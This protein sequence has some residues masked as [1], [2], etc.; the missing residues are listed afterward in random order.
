MQERQQRLTIG[1]VPLHVRQE[2]PSTVTRFDA[3]DQC[4]DRIFHAHG[5]DDVVVKVLGQ[6]CAG[7]SSLDDTCDQ[8]KDF[9]HLEGARY[10]TVRGAVDELMTS[11][12]GYVVT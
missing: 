3:E 5:C 12:S 6:L 1:K 8:L 7:S 4:L 10:G 9:G 2:L 11:L